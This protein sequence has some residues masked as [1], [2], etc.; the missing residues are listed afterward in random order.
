MTKPT[1]NKVNEAIAY[2]GVELVKGN[3]YFY[4][5]DT[6]SRYIAD[7]IPSVYSPRLTTMSLEKWVEY[8]GCNLSEAGM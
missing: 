6:G 5:A 8:V 7:W 3:G 4:F 1:L 2:Y